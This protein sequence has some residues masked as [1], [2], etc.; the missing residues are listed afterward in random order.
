MDS[1][2]SASRSDSVKLCNFFLVRSKS[3]KTHEKVQVC[4]LQINKYTYSYK[5]MQQLVTITIFILSENPYFLNVINFLKSAVWHR[6]M[7]M[8]HMVV[9]YFDLA[10]KYGL[11][12]HNFKLVTYSGRCHRRRVLCATEH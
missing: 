3:K 8:P 1:T 11:Y 2:Q 9:E 4:T 7:A 10:P 6:K 12:I 5:Q